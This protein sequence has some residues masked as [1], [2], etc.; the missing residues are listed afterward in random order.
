MFHVAPVFRFKMIV[1]YLDTENNDGKVLH[2]HKLSV[3]RVEC[4]DL[5]TVQKVKWSSDWSQHPLT[6]MAN[7]ILYLLYS[8]SLLIPGT[9]QGRYYD[10]KTKEGEILL[11]RNDSLKSLIQSVKRQKPPV[12]PETNCPG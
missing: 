4:E 6:S 7:T 8:P 1:K 9:R 10:Q 12:H 3:N 5:C 2:V 11:S